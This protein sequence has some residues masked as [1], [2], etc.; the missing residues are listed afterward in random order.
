MNRDE[1]IE[2]ATKSGPLLFFTFL[3]LAT[4][5]VGLISVR[6]PEER[7]AFLMKSEIEHA[8][9]SSIV[10]TDIGSLILVKKDFDAN[11]GL[12]LIFTDIH[13]TGDYHKSRYSIDYRTVVAV[14]QNGDSLYAEKKDDYFRQQKEFF[15]VSNQ[16]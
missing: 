13:P 14:Y 6:D 3:L 16:R 7:H 1:F 4:V 12:Q 2:S 9:D 10:E 8:F 15:S 5:I 11:G